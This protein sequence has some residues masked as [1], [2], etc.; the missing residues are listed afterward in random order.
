MMENDLLQAIPLFVYSRDHQR[1]TLAE[2][3]LE[4]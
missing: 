3:L 4:P 2:E 1:T